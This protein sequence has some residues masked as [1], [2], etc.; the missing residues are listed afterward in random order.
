M[1]PFGASRAGL[2]STRVDAIPDSGGTHQWD[3]NEGSGSTLADSIG[4][5][6]GAING[7]TWQSGDGTDDVYLNYDGIDDHVSL[8]PESQSEFTHFTD[9]L[10]GTI[11]FWI[12][13]T[14]L[15][16][17][18]YTILGGSASS[19]EV[20][21]LFRIDG[22][23]SLNWRG[24]S[25]NW[26]NV[27]SSGIGLSEDSWQPVAATSDGST[28]RIY[29]GDPIDEKANGSLSG[30]SSDDWTD[31]IE[32]GREARDGGQ[33]PFEGGIDIGFVDDSARSTSELQ[34]FVDDTRKFY[35]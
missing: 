7:A 27:Q 28:A 2:M 32:I 24:S 1:A 8:G 25:T 29:H 31:P 16:G 6:D 10:E 30:G 19:S 20:G 4:A 17:S 35:E 18:T 11:F 9:E 34:N 13:P 26:W 22:S 12:K 14:Q 15:D 3:T 33:N 5:L 23:D 21:A